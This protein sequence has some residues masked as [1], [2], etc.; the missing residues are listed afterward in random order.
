MPTTFDTSLVRT[1]GICGGRLRIDGTRMTVN[2]VVL[3]HKQGL[4]APQIVQQYPQR[5]LS[6]IYTVLAWYYAHEAEFDR[7]MAEEAIADERAIQEIAASR[8]G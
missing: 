7:E 2:Q 5:T 1:P 4:S 6:E 3:L 8:Q